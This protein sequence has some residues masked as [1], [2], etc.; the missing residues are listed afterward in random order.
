MTY[1]QSTHPPRIFVPCALTISIELWARTMGISSSG[2][3]GSHNGFD[4]EFG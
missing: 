1:A 4:S 2:L 3:V